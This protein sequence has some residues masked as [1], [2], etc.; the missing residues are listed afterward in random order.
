MKLLSWNFDGVT[1]LFQQVANRIRADILNGRYRPDEQLPSVRQFAF[2]ASVNPNTMQKA[3]MKLEEEGFIIRSHGK[4]ISIN[5]YAD[6]CIP[7]GQRENL[8]LLSK[9]RVAEAAVKAHV[10]EGT[11]VML[12]AS[13]TTLQTVEFL[14]KINNVI[15]ITSGIQTLV[16]LMKTS[17]RFY[18][19]GG[20]AL[21]ESSSFVG[22]TAIEALKSFNADVCFVS[23]HGLSEEGF[24]TDTSERENDVRAMMMKHSRHRVLLIDETKVNLNYWHN[25][26]HVSEFDDVYCTAPLPE[27]I[28]KSV[29]RFHLV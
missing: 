11:V 9:K 4:A 14:G 21:N 29:K 15:V 7:Y 23:C 3:L 6:K 12:D 28:M 1:P 25:L 27:H 13:S 8:G 16:E 26:A 5:L 18:S 22:Q 2:D 10:R 17:V 20:R 24:A 19:T